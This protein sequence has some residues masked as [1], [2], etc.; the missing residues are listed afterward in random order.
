MNMRNTVRALQNTLFRAA[1]QSLDRKFGA[2]YDKVYREDVLWTAWRQVRANDGAP[3]VDRQSFEHIEDVIGVEAFLAELTE[4]L[5]EQRYRPQAVRRCWIEKPG[6]PEKRPLGIPVIRD[7]VVQAAV[8]IVIEPIF[9]ANFLPCSYGFRPKRSQH[10]AIRQV[11]KAITF[12]KQTVVIDA[13]IKGCYDNIR[14]DL[15]LNLVQRRIS[16]QRI[17][18]L[19]RG[20]LKAGVMDGG[21]YVPSGEMGTPQGGV[22]SPLLANIYLHS[23]DK[24][25]QIA[26]IPGTLVRFADDI[27][28]LLWRNGRQVL[29]KVREMLG[30]LGLTLHPEKTRVVA[31]AEGFDFLGV[32][33]RLRPVRKQNPRIKFSCRIWASDR[34]VLRI[35][36][37]VKEVIGRRYGTALEE[38]IRE[39]NPVLRGWNNYQ[40]AV[41]PERKR[42]LKLNSFVRERFRI[43]LKRKYNDQSRGARRVHGN[44]LVRLGLFQLG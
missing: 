33:F 44:V 40:T 2:L 1:K 32:H 18:K 9:E 29:E 10:L 23:F 6:K 13:D 4:E 26:K 41:Q 39:M 15:L 35:K 30:R 22:I 20:W 38:L 8:K 12:G 34:S 43:F 16:D 36:Q 24:M 11:Q 21:V 25:F 31:A 28:I 5:R 27:V 17:L 37:R 7:R 3:G 42:S 19:I 14:H